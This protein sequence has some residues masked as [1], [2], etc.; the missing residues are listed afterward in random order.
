MLDCAIDLPMG[1]L[2]LLSPPKQKA[3]KEFIHPSTSPVEVRLFFIK[4]NNYID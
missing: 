2:Y 1:K 3:I 4:K